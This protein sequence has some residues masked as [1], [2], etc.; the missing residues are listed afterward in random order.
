MKF[1]KHLSPSAVLR[2]WWAI[3]RRRTITTSRQHLFQKHYLAFG[4]V[5][6]IMRDV[7]VIPSLNLFCE[8][9]QQVA[10]FAS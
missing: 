1:Q 6:F 2:R 3:S 9:L 5:N 4:H 8:P 10:R 7:L